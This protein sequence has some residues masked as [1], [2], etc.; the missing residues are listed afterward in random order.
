MKCKYRPKYLTKST[1]YFMNSAFTI[2]IISSKTKQSSQEG[3][4]WRFYNPKYH[5]LYWF[6][7]EYWPLVV[8]SDMLQPLQSTP[9]QNVLGFLVNPCN[10]NRPVPE[11]QTPYLLGGWLWAQKELHRTCT[12]PRSLGMDPFLE[13]KKE[14][15]RLHLPALISWHKV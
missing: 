3:I 7:L 4:Q 6:I 1:M 8:L 11:Q 10:H 15:S 9:N 2:F 14:R 5:F 12:D 13:I